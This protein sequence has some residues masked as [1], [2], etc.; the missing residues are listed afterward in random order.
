MQFK[1]FRVLWGLLFLLLFTACVSGGEDVPE[2]SPVPS[3]TVPAATVQN[4]VV[5]ESTALPSPSPLIL[6][7]ENVD[8]N[9]EILTLTEP[10]SDLSS[11]KSAFAALP[12]LKDFSAILLLPSMEEFES[13]RNFLS[14]WDDILAA[15]PSVKANI[16]FSLS[17][18]TPADSVTEWVPSSVPEDASDY[19]TSLSRILP[20]LSQLDL[21]SVSLSRNLI[22]AY[23]ADHPSCS[24]LW[25]DPSYGSSSS[26][27]SSVCISGNVDSESLQEYISCFPLL[28]ELDL[29]NSSFPEAE[30]NALAN[31]HPDLSMHRMITM[32]GEKYDSYSESLDFS[33]AKIDN[34]EMFSASLFFFP[35]LKLLT[36]HDC[37]LSDNQLGVIREQH[38]DTKVVWTVHFKKWKVQTD[39]IAFSTKQDGYNTN[40]LRASDVDGLRYCTDLIALDLGHNA[41]TNL[42]FLK[43]LTNL[44]VLILSDN[45]GLKDISA[46]GNLTKL[47]YLELF[48]LQITD[49]SALANLSDLLDINLCITRVEDLSPLLS[50]KKLERIWIGNQTQSYLKKESL[51]QL[52]EAFPNAKYD[53]TSVSST[54]LG[55]REHPRFDA[56]SEMFRTNAPVAPFVPEE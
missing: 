12:S 16:S 3:A 54:N 37:S 44:Q 29:L 11:V 33:K 50:C 8:P 1:Q 49:I 18:G 21:R 19:L 31:Q 4:V 47:K 55:W 56:Y 14:S 7:G 53:L 41:I 52:L 28:G 27:S 26:L 13:V 35:K 25:E 22:A 46:I 2:S 40:R 51:Q 42:D 5:P 38:P 9:A 48:M 30:A 36:M 17:D 43:P 34:P 45:R 10:V 32:L 15:Y 6:F 20:N 24:V 23:I 39:A